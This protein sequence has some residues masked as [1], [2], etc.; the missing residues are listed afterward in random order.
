MNSPITEA[1]ATISN[2]SPGL[3]AGALPFQSD[4]PVQALIVSTINDTHSARTDL[5]NI[6]YGIISPNHTRRNLFPLGGA[7]DDA[8]S[9]S[10]RPRSKGKL[11]QNPGNRDVKD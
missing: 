3:I 5:S 4:V 10:M 6:R 9:E 11:R 8:R 7:S 1:E 2:F